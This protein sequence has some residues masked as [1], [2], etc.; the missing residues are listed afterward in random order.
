VTRRPD[1][2]RLSQIADMVCRTARRGAVAAIGRIPPSGGTQKMDSRFGSRHA[3]EGGG[4]E[5]ACAAAARRGNV[6]AQKLRISR[7]AI[8]ASPRFVLEPS[9]ISVTYRF[10][11]THRLTCRGRCNGVGSRDKGMRPRS[12]CNALVRPV[13][14]LRAI[15]VLPQVSILLSIRRTAVGCNLDDHPAIR[16]PASDYLNTR[17]MS[18]PVR[19]V[20]NPQSERRIV[21]QSLLHWCSHCLHRRRCHRICSN[22]GQNRAPTISRLRL[23]AVAP[24]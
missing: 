8:Q 21:F 16:P 1:V 5:G 23:V 10:G 19:H 24:V 3:G 11:I 18:R 12:E 9:C 14:A 22:Q 2:I 15:R 20:D 7:R 13:T 17:R 4:R 6:I